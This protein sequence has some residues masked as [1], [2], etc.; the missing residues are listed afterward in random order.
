MRY[1]L[2]ILLLFACQGQEKIEDHSDDESATG[3]TEQAAD[4]PHNT[5][6]SSESSA[7]DTPAEVQELP[8]TPSYPSRDIPVI[9]D[10]DANNEIDDQHALAYLL[11]NE[12][13]FNV[14]GITVNATRNGGQIEQHYEEAERVIQ[15]CGHAPEEL[16]YTGANAD[17]N[18]IRS[19]TAQGSYDGQEA[20]EFIIAT[21][22]QYDDHRLALVPVGK[23]T[24]IALALMLAPDIKDKVRIVWLGANYPGPGEYNLDNDI[25]AMNYVLEQ[26]VPF[27]MVTV[28]Y[29]DGT[30]SAAVRV[31]PA[32]MQAR[33]PGLGPRVATAVPGRNG[34][35][36]QHFGD[37]SISLFENLELH[38]TPPGRSLF[39]VVALAIMKNP[40][41]GKQYLLSSPT[42]VDGQWVDRPE[43]ERL[44]TVWENF[45]K[46]A[47]LDDFFNSLQVEAPQ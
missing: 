16:L 8:P 23:L 27:E 10:T 17:F 24:N 21:A 29:S 34:G 36:F 26:D 40:E 20:V 4:N 30:G 18:T 5:N 6:N 15:L 43:N 3:T 46:A 42:Y 45:D 13:T 25:P 31:T 32:E 7:V 33:M 44:I 35:E 38:G 11:L 19:Q 39:D 14:L 2:P 22:R 37:Y 12:A 47:I 9:F 28:R 41:W 1:L